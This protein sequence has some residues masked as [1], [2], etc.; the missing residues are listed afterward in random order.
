MKLKG[1]RFW[2]VALIDE[3]V[4]KRSPSEGYRGEV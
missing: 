4:Q 3:F 1:M 2:F